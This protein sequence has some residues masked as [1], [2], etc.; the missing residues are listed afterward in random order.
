MS[1]LNRRSQSLPPVTSMGSDRVGNSRVAKARKP[2]FRSQIKEHNGISFPQSTSG[3]AALCTAES[4]PILSKPA[5]ESLAP[6]LLPNAGRKTW[7]AMIMNDEVLCSKFE[8]LMQYLFEAGV[9]EDLDLSPQ[10]SCLLGRDSPPK[11]RHHRTEA[12]ERR[13]ILDQACKDRPLGNGKPL[14]LNRLLA[15]YGRGEYPLGGQIAISHQLDDGS[16]CNQCQALQRGC[17]RV[18]GDKFWT[19]SQCVLCVERKTPCSLDEY[20]VKGRD[21]TK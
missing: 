19:R 18:D 14:P 17:I 12:A 9:R 13:A 8:D 6:P 4:S 2:V 5:A 15:G 20:S 1:L 7:L 3:D 16:R 21:P 10:F 11:N